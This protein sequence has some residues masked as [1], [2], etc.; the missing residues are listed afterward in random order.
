MTP[1]GFELE[2]TNSIMLRSRGKRRKV[3]SSTAKEDAATRGESD[4]PRFP[5]ADE[6]PNIQ[7]SDTKGLEGDERQPNYKSCPENAQVWDLYLKEANL[8]GQELTTLWNNGLDSF[9][10]FA[11]LFAGNITSFLIESRGDLKED[12]QERL[13]EDIR[14][15][16]MNEPISSASDFQPDPSSL[17]VNALW[18]CSFTLT[19]ISAL[20]GVLAKGWIAYYDPVSRVLATT[21]LRRA[22]HSNL[23]QPRAHLGDHVNPYD[24]GDTVIYHLHLLA[25]VF[26][27]IPIPDANHGYSRGFC[28]S[29]AAQAKLTANQ[30]TSFA[31]AV[32]LEGIDN[33]VLERRACIAKE[34][35][36]GGAYIGVDYRELDRRTNGR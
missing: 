34:D 18:Y 2:F 11:G 9:L 22:C 13:P 35:G 26:S 8:E 21:V 14:S 27:R 31:Q 25:S 19:L 5:N 15:I 6:H 29:E 1:T 23:G 10:I 3:T 20:S 16:L 36:D 28:P 17:H 30:S 33:V 32:F 4:S 12:P 24:S 7:R